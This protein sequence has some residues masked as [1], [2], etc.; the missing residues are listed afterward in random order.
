[1]ILSE[2]IEATSQKFNVA[3]VQILSESGLP[4]YLAEGIILGLLAD[5]REKKAIE[6]TQDLSNR[7]I[8]LEKKNDEMEKINAELKTQLKDMK[9][10]LES[11][12]DPSADVPDV[13]DK[14]SPQLIEAEK[15][16]TGGGG[17]NVKH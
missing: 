13:I 15:G 17:V 6:L 2:L 16:N 8:E 7:N 5:V 14:E 3:A 9:E 4:A 12:P 10:K 1:M 11:V